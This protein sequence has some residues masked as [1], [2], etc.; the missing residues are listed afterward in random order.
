MRR[1]LYPSRT[2]GPPTPWP[3]DLARVATDRL[4]WR[5]LGIS[6][7]VTLDEMYELEIV[8]TQIA[9]DLLLRWEDAQQKIAQAKAIRE[10]QSKG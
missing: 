4:L 8:H 3:S 6:R 5:E 10:A 9:L 1:A 7:N 2:S